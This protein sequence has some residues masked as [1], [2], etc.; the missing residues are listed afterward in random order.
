MGIGFL[1]LGDFGLAFLSPK[2]SLLT[3]LK[4]FFRDPAMLDLSGEGTGDLG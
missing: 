3:D 4:G 1:P 2:K